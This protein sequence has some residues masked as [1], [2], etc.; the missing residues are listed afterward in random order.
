MFDKP[1]DPRDT[2][3][4]YS[5]QEIEQRKAMADT[6]RLRLANDVPGAPVNAVM[7]GGACRMSARSLMEQKACELEQRAR[8]LRMLSRA[9]PLELPIEADD[10]LFQLLLK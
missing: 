7:E 4:L 10:A 8:R 9:L 5:R 6:N 1:N 2:E 3:S